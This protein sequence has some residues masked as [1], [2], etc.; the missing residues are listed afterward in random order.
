M[1]LCCGMFKNVFSVVDPLL[2]ELLFT[3]LNSQMSHLLIATVF[4]LYQQTL[5][6]QLLFGIHIPKPEL[7][8]AIFFR[9]SVQLK[10][11]L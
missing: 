11:E 3:V 8:P 7:H 4:P 6:D 2:M 10:E 1:L 9:M 5:R